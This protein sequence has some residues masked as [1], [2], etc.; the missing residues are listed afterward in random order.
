MYEE[1]KAKAKQIRRE[2]IEAIYYAKSGHPGGSLSATD[3]LVALYYKHMKNISVAD[4][5]NPDRDRFILSKGHACPALYAILA[6]LGF[7]PKEDLHTLRHPGSHLQ[8][9]PDIKKTPGIDACAGSLGQGLS[10]AAGMAMGAKKAG[11]DL[12]VYCMLGDGEMQEGQIWE[13][14][15]ACAHY[16]LDNL[17]VL[18]DNNGLQ[19]DGSNDEVMRLGSIAD[20]MRAFGLETIELADG[21][22]FEAI[23]AA[24]NAPHNGRPKA[25]VAHTVKGKGVSFMENAVAWHGSTPNDAQYAQAMDELK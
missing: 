4:P 11:R 10:V 13:A 14:L 21:H 25:I 8:G 23:F 6:D 19:I 22:D 1:L 16:G 15:M 20:K 24:L 18:V 9:Q 7:F 17:T 5:K 12:Q 3:M 2:A